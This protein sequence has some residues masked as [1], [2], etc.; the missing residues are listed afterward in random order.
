MRIAILALI[1]SFLIF[2]C[3]RNDEKQD[4]SL[5]QKNSRK[6][7]TG[8]GSIG[9]DKSTSSSSSL[10]EDLGFPQYQPLSSVFPNTLE[11]MT[12]A[13]TTDTLLKLTR[14]ASPT[15]N[16]HRELENIV[17]SIATTDIAHV[18]M[19]M[20]AVYFSYSKYIGILGELKTLKDAS[21]SYIEITRKLRIEK[22]LAFSLAKT[23]TQIANTGFPKATDLDW[24]K[25]IA[26]LDL[27][28]PQGGASLAFNT[29]IKKSE[30]LSIAQKDQL[31]LLTSMKYEAE[32]SS[33][34]AIGLFQNTSDKSLNAL[35]SF[36]DRLQW[37]S[38]DYTLIKGSKFFPKLTHNEVIQ[39]L[40]RQYSK[41]GSVAIAVYANSSEKSHEHVM[42]IAETLNSDGKTYFIKKAMLF[43]Q[44]ITSEQMIQLCQIA[45]SVC[46][47]VV[48]RSIPK[49]QDP[50]PEYAVAI[51]ALVTYG[52]KDIWIT[53]V[54]KYFSILTTEQAIKLINASYEGKSKV[55]AD[56]AEKIN[57]MDAENAVKIAQIFYYDAKDQW[58]LIAEPF[59]K[60]PLGSQIALFASAGYEKKRELAEKLFLKVTLKNVADI[61][62]MSEV[63]YYGDKDKWI[64]FALALMP[65]FSGDEFYFA[66]KAAYEEKITI[67]EKYIARINELTPASTSKIA[68][69]IF[70][71]GDK[72]KWLKSAA[73][74]LKKLTVEELKIVLQS[75]YEEKLAIGLS[76]I[77]KISD[78]DGNGA[79]SIA[80]FVFI[81]GDKDKWLESA[82]QNIGSI[83]SEEV[84]K[85][86]DSAYEEKGNLSVAMIAK[87]SNLTV[88]NA[89]AISAHLSYQDKD[90]FLLEAVDKVTDL[91]RSNID[92]FIKASYENHDELR[93]KAQNRIISIS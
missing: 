12:S 14:V 37:L 24:N 7:S 71:Y 63:L 91:T 17:S 64:N 40:A 23:L 86:I 44:E 60:S 51:A 79:A 29:L 73:A 46:S 77:K 20:D 50:T 80:K 82:I 33:D 52:N 36:V 28:Y 15:Q 4:P 84:I 74:I 59:I 58:L 9:L 1:S 18:K 56:L 81:Y 83:T 3:G 30:P 62:N 5:Q 21:A 76:L 31:M 42:S 70:Y 72:D 16:Y 68:R 67:A 19:L 57:D 85:I 69:D 54:L 89:I 65:Q 49:W 39:M 11:I 41:D 32:I 8:S 27:L 2:A 6:N 93:K 90:K 92:S 66:L 55:G 45:E 53:G 10:P 25:G 13:D 61:V 75:G 22:A 47:E 88:A 78:L 35:L 48:T 26:A 38:R 87:A 34:L 43:Y